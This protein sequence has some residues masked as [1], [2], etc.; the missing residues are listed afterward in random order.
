MLGTLKFIEEVLNTAVVVTWLFNTGIWL[1]VFKLHFW[2]IQFG[3]VIISIGNNRT[4]QIKE[5]FQ[6]SNICFIFALDYF[7]WKGV[8]PVRADF[9]LKFQVH[10]TKYF[11][12]F[13]KHLNVYFNWFN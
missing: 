12:H 4:F 9:S 7:N 11:G 1:S 13:F 2:S 3:I 6:I 10:L 5:N 8:G